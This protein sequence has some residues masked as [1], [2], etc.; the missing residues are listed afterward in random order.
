M[1]ENDN[2]LAGLR[3]PDCLQEER[4][5]IEGSSVFKVFDD[6]TDGHSDVEWDDDSFVHCP[7]CGHDGTLA[8]F[9]IDEDADADEDE[10][11]DADADEEKKEAAE[12]KKSKSGPSCFF[13]ARRPCVG[14]MA[15]RN[16]ECALLDIGGAYA[17]NHEAHAEIA[18]GQLAM[19][20]LV[21]PLLQELVP[22][23]VDAMPTL[24]KVVRRAL[25]KLDESMD[26]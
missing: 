3:C 11:E 9:R 12:V 4:L 7:E 20:E 10:D 23:L 14:C 15:Y 25:V 24:E 8:E 26:D 16:K 17:D 1:V 5:D 6:G 22:I 18:R 13:N 19:Q 2:C 21:Q